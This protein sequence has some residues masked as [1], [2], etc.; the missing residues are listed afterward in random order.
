ME[1]CASLAILPDQNPTAS[2]IP[3]LIANINN[4]IYFK[5]TD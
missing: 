3:L 2:P 1:I 5:F 4:S